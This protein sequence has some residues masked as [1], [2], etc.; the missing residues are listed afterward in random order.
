MTF[1][2]NP[3][4]P[5]QS[6]LIDFGFMLD[7]STAASRAGTSNSSSGDSIVTDTLVGTEGFFAPESLSK[8]E[9][10]RKSD[11]WQLG[12]VLYTMLVG[13]HP[14][15]TQ[16]RFSSPYLSSLVVT[17]LRYRANILAGSYF[18]LSASDWQAISPQAKDLVSKLL[19][20]KPGDRLEI[21]EILK[22]PWMRACDACVAGVGLD[23]G[24]GEAYHERIKMLAAHRLQY[25]PCRLSQSEADTKPSHV[26]GSA[27]KRQKRDHNDVVAES[28]SL[29]IPSGE[30]RR[31]PSSSLSIDRKNDCQPAAKSV[32]DRPCLCPS[33]PIEKQSSEEHIQ[34]SR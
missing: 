22:H 27:E 30:L 10:S 20:V 13:Y 2:A 19:T 23:A 11:I 7:L 3:G 25:L 28:D 21:D 12:C 1:S 32:E 26:V 8:C 17:S 4:D 14:F 15:S 33:P 18:P 9:Y 16:K 31:S 34:S 6:K 29:K 5:M 24:L